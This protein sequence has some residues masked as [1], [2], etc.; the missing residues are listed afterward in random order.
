MASQIT[1]LASGSEA[2]IGYNIREAM[3]TNDYQNID[4]YV[5]VLLVSGILLAIFTIIATYTAW[6]TILP[7]SDSNMEAIFRSKVG[8]HVMGIPNK[9]ALATIYVY[10]AWMTIMLWQLLPLTWGTV[11]A[12][13]ALALFFYLHFIFSGLSRVIMHSKAM[14]DEPIFSDSQ[15]L[16]MQ[17]DD[18]DKAF[19][20]KVK[21]NH[22]R[23]CSSIFPSRISADDVRLQYAINGE[24]DDESRRSISCSEC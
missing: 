22:R 8:V 24:A 4:L 12:A 2:G 5:G 23:P 6:G 17:Q 15:M 9:L 14:K 3:H 10:L 18:Y 11:Y 16:E 13:L 19:M 1:I 20:D 21:M 7:V